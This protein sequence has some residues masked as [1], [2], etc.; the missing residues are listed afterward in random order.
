TR[1]TTVQSQ[2]VWSSITC[3]TTR[4]ASILITSGR[5]PGSRTRSIARGQIEGPDLVSVASDGAVRRGSGRHWSVTTTNVT[6][7]G[8]SKQST[9]QQ[10][11]LASSDCGFI[12]IAT[13][14]RTRGT[15]ERASGRH[16]DRRADRPGPD[17]HRTAGGGSSLRLRHL[18]RLRDQLLGSGPADGDRKSVV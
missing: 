8:T 6:T 4:G 17:L 5:S 7:A 3:A 12:P 18:H 16:R 9:R 15:N 13:K 14:T 11:Q 1:S 2:T 10:R